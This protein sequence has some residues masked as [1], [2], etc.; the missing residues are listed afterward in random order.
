M[1]CVMSCHV[2]WVNLRNLVK[3]LTLKNAVKMR[4][5]EETRAFIFVEHRGL[6][7]LYQKPAQNRIIIRFFT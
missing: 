3:C 5:S 4:V 6:E 7:P 2:F 1:F